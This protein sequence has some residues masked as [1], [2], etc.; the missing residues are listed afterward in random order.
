MGRYR[1]LFLLFAVP[2]VLCLAGLRAAEPPAQDDVGESIRT[3]TRVYDLI[4][5]NSAGILDP[6][7]AIYEG[8]IPG[9]LR[10]LDPHS[11]F[12]DR[13]EFEEFREEQ[14][15]RYYGVGMTVGLRDKGPTVIQPYPGSPAFKTGL[16]PADLLVSIDGKPVAGLSISEV[17]D[18]LKGPRGTRT[19]VVVLRYGES[20]PLAFEMV[21]EEI[22]ERSVPEAFW[23]RPGVAYIQVTEFNENTSKELEE[24]IQWLDENSMQGLILDLRGNPGGILVECVAVA[25]R[26][27]RKGQTIVSHRGRSSPEQ[28]Y[29]AKRGDRGYDYPIVVLVDGDTASASEIVAG[30]LQDHDRAWI[31]GDST[32]GKGLVQTPYSLSDDAGLTLTTAKYYTPSG[33]LIQRDYSN[34]SILDYYGKRGAAAPGKRVESRTTDSGRQVFGGGGI[35][36]DQKYTDPGYSRFQKELLESAAFFDFAPQYLAGRDGKIPNSWAPDPKA[37]E[38]FRDFLVA[39]SIPFSPLE[40]ALHSDWIGL[41]LRRQILVSLFGFDQGRRLDIEND[42]EVELA[43]KALPKAR[44]LSEGARHLL[45]RK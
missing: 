43:S 3:F 6:E 1:R 15:G 34:V 20:A 33:R 42:P 5:S 38:Q 8:A 41:H 4:E 19:T 23:Y 25:D 32:F 22:P 14:R 31:L 40:F 18:R 10:T 26:F 24:K 30:A 2:L 29:L 37:L 16:R 27:L 35:T 21:R 9:M 12:F 39:R 44:A 28:P 7:K 45:V 36:P 11:R 13:K 17:A